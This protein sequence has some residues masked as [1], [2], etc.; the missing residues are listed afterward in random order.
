MT[1]FDLKEVDVNNNE[2]ISDSEVLI[3]LKC[4]SKT[5][6]KR[7]SQFLQTDQIYY[8][9]QA[10]D[11][12]MEEYEYEYVGNRMTKHNLTNWLDERGNNINVHIIVYNK[13]VSVNQT[14]PPFTLNNTV[15]VIVDD[16]IPD[17]PMTENGNIMMIWNEDLMSPFLINMVL[18]KVNSILCKIDIPV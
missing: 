12:R 6:P 17:S 1:N 7:L 14:M 9:V 8:S 16:D 2:I 4:M 11:V 3:W 15:Q 18:E 5:H 13:Q 10:V